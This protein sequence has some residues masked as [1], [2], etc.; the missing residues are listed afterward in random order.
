MDFLSA[1]NH[2]TSPEHIKSALYFLWY[3]HS[4]L[5]LGITA[6]S[7]ETTK[8]HSQIHPTFPDVAVVDANGADARGSSFGVTETGDEV[9]GKNAEVRFVAEGGGRNI[10]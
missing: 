1:Y 3:V 8:P 10:N 7:T 2:K 9:E 4:N 5:D 6:P